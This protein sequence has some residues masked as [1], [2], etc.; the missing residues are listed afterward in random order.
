MKKIKLSKQQTEEINSWINDPTSHQYELVGFAQKFASK[1]FGVNL[2][3]ST[4]SINDVD[5]ILKHIHE[6]EPLVQE[7]LNINILALRF[8]AYII[9]TLEHNTEKGK[10]E[11]DDRISGEQSFPFY[12]RGMT[13]FPLSWCFERMLHGKEDNIN[14]KYHSVLMISDIDMDF[15][16]QPHLH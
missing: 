5:M 12:W 2:D 14:T 11:R 16:F 10:W 6:T 1:C 8:A 15:L 4:E 9:T 3:L 7:N 13:F